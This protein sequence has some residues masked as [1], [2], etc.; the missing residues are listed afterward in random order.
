[1]ARTITVY[2]VAIS[3]TLCVSDLRAT[4][5]PPPSE[6]DREAAFTAI[7]HRGAL[8]TLGDRDIAYRASDHLHGRQ[9]CKIQFQ[10]KPL[11]TNEVL[12]AISCFQELRSLAIYG[13]GITDAG[14]RHLVL[15]RNLRTLD[16]EGARISDEGLQ[17]LRGMTH[18][19][20][21]TLR[22]N[23]VNGSCL[24]YLAGARNLRS[25]VIQSS[26]NFSG[27][28]LRF[29][30]PLKSLVSLECYPCSNL[31][32]ADLVVLDSLKTLE[33]IHLG[34]G[35]VD[36]AGLKHFAGLSHL[37]HLDLEFM[38]IK[39]SGLV[40][41]SALSLRHLSLRGTRVD[42]KAVSRL[43]KLSRLEELYLWD[44]KVTDGC[45]KYLYTMSRLKVV[46]VRGTAVSTA[47]LKRLHAARPKIQIW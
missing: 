40:S 31:T 25:L 16:I 42:D 41:L 36:D 47:G 27:T 3:A 38:R 9:V 44:T 11:A 14:L 30:R 7:L 26:P 43:R 8:V 10:G 6:R 33:W 20:D 37:N 12:R 13:A 15:L 21:L 29:L 45:L 2:F 39:G 19:R 18:L 17:C 35:A 46:Q 4:P 23:P 28:S 1:M 24:R 34:G 32:N 22:G 5:S